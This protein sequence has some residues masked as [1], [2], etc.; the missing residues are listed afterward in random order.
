LYICALNSFRAYNYK[1]LQTVYA[2][3][4][5]K[6]VKLLLGYYYF[7]NFITGQKTS[8]LI[9]ELFTN[10]E[11]T[12]YEFFHIQRDRQMPPNYHAGSWLL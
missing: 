4:S 5:I 3:A 10:F 7:Y 1:L 8:R 11:T 12:D 9:K 6:H 2:G